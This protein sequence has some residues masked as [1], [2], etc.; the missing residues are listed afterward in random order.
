MHLLEV[1]HL[2]TQFRSKSGNVMAAA[3]VNFDIDEGKIVAIVGESG[4]GKSVTAQSILQL[5]SRPGKIVGGEILLNGEDLLK[6]SRKEMCHVRGKEISM[7]FQEPMTS[8]NPTFT[9][10]AQVV[11]VLR[12]HQKMT[13]KEAREKAVE[14]FQQV[15]IPDAE[16]RL[17][18]YPH[19]LSGGMRQRVMIAIAL[20]CKPRILIADEPTT[21]LDVT[22]QAQILELLK[23]LQKETG[24]SILLITH[25]FG[26]VSE[27]AN[28]VIVMYAG[29]TLEKGTVREVM[30][31]PLHPYTKGLLKAI[32]SLSGQGKRG[33]ERLFNI[34][35]VVPNLAK[36]PQGCSFCPRCTES[37]PKCKE[38]MPPIVELEDGRQV[39]CW[40][41]E[42][43]GETN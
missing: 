21:A 30:D 33:G 38:E 16:S 42:R 2:N 35:G 27:L 32:P 18:E 17:D 24:M 5:I 22:I 28:D 1:K 31:A 15:G 12:L 39:R 6:K 14:L 13:K 36:L 20:A 10:G 25:D 4:S 26:V 7:I 11:E 37:I 9:C 29:R 8:L 3:D 40:L 23:K 19:Q 34:E 41:Y 43:K